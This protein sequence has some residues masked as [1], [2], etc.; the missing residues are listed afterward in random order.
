VLVVIPFVLFGVL[1]TR[2]RPYHFF[3]AFLGLDLALRVAYLLKVGGDFME[4]RFIWQSYPVLI[5]AF[6]VGALEMARRTSV[7]V[8]VF[9]T[10]LALS[11]VKSDVVLEAKYGMQSAPEMDGYAKLGIRIGRALGD[12]L[13]ERTVVATTLAGTIGYFGPELVIIDQW[14]LN[15]RYVATLPLEKLPFNSRGHL[16]FAPDSY[17]AER[18]VNLYMAHPVIC[19]CASPCVEAKPN[20]FI[21]LGNDECV[22]T[23][24]FKQDARLTNYFC[25]HPEHFVLNRVDCR[26]SGSLPVR[27]VSLVAEAGQIAEVE[28]EASHVN[29]VRVVAETPHCGDLGVQSEPRT[30]AEIEADPEAREDAVGRRHARHVVLSA[31]DEL[32]V[33]RRDTVDDA[34]RE[35]EAHAL[36]EIEIDQQRSVQ[37]KDV[38]VL[39]RG[40]RG[41]PTFEAEAVPL[42]SRIERDVHRALE[43]VELR[44]ESQGRHVVHPEAEIDLVGHAEPHLE[45]RRHGDDARD[46]FGRAVAGS[47]DRPDLGTKSQRLRRDGEAQLA[48]RSRAGGAIGVGIGTPRKR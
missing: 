35:H 28:A 27:G 48:R 30:Q 44:V 37:I 1:A 7:M 42:D 47:V 3:A 23:W 25:A 38:D 20:V 43:K 45:R 46:L 41:G 5:A 21:R 33:A 32:G 29:Q 14:G 9:A 19:S 36:V 26:T 12:V 18:G 4:Y 13:P 39:A 17:L 11:L 15:D 10:L 6:L 31:A 2:G 8:P 40:A 24:Y 34:R 16:K 22:R